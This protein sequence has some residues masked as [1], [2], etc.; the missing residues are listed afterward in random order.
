MATDGGNA[1]ALVLPRPRERTGTRRLG[2]RRC[3]RTG[4]SAPRRM[5][6]AS[7]CMIDYAGSHFVGFAPMG[8]STPYLRRHDEWHA[9]RPPSSFLTCP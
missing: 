4:D 8:C 9:H 3:C 5:T 7:V 1:H 2:Q 6:N